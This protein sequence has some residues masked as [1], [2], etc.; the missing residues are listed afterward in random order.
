[1]AP[2]ILSR[3]ARNNPD[4]VGGLPQSQLDQAKAKIR[5]HTSGFST[6]AFLPLTFTPTPGIQ[7]VLSQHLLPP[8]RRA[9]FKLVGIV[10]KPTIPVRICLLVV[11]MA[12]RVLRVVPL[13]V[14]LVRVRIGVG[15][16]WQ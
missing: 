16:D 3:L 1:M 6:A 2:A 12:R 10:G 5:P 14:T 7:A 8:E 4:G 15:M 9:K 13:D 11:M